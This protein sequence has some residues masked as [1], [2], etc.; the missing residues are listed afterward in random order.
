MSNIEERFRALIPRYPEF[1]KQVAVIT[2]G[3]N[4]IGLGIVLRLAREG[5]RIVIADMDEQ[6]LTA[7]A[8][9]LHGQG[10]DVV[11]FAGNV[12]QPDTIRALFKTIVENFD[13]VDLL[14]NNAADLRR[15]RLLV[16]HEA[17]LDHQLG[18][19]IRGPYLCSYYAAKIMRARGG[20]N[21]IHLSSVG[22]QRAHWK[23]FPYDM[24]KGAI[25]ALT[26]AMA[27]DLA[28]YNIR[29]NAIGPGVT[30]KANV[31][32]RPIH[33]EIIGRIPLQRA[34]TPEDTSALV[35][36]LASTEASYITG[37]VIYIDGGITAQLS[38]PGIRL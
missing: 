22:A 5:M 2:G 26:R 4:G 14:V 20:G 28:E 18:N 27:I 33:P 23:G 35:A 19:N 15:R 10:V 38:P 7:V 34:G 11:P 24:T 36:F 25:N 29:V 17:L 13:S 37:Q 6:A 12:S 8:S 1:Q 30:Y 9:A 3:A 32:D 21:I 31:A 16:E